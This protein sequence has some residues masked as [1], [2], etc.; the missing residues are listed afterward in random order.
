MSYTRVPPA[1]HATSP[2]L[3]PGP[4]G[5]RHLPAGPSPSPRP[6]RASHAA[7]PPRH[8]NPLPSAVLPSGPQRPALLCTATPGPQLAASYG[9]SWQPAHP[10]PVRRAAVLAPCGAVQR[11]DR[12]PVPFLQP[13]AATSAQAQ[14][15]DADGDLKE[16]DEGE[17]ELSYDPAVALDEVLYRPGEEVPYYLGPL[18]VRETPGGTAGSWGMGRG[19]YTGRMCY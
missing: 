17:N 5:S 7:L 9:G 6:R 15:T 4:A 12:R 13:I 1:A 3:R 10:A 14:D 19:R 8:L 2:C 16:A 18:E 11:C